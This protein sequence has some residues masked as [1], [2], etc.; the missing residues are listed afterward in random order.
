MP[1]E[2]ITLRIDA[3]VLGVLRARAVARKKSVSDLVNTIVVERVRD[4]V[5]PADG[6]EVI[7]PELQG[8]VRSTV[9][10]AAEELESRLVHL[11]ERAAVG[12]HAGRLEVFQL[13]V[14]RFGLEG[15]QRIHED[16]S[17]E[18]SRRLE[19]TLMRFAAKRG[20]A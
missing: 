17:R 15:A 13:L 14:K 4:G 20:G 7:L 9:N 6:L 19:K 11:L 16:A 5:S 1:R 3:G 18:A 10:L 2:Q 8:I 12:S